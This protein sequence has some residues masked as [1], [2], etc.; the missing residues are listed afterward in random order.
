[1]YRDIKLCNIFTY[2]QYIWDNANIIILR[3]RALT[4]YCTYRKC[5]GYVRMYTKNYHRYSKQLCFR[6][7]LVTR[8][9]KPARPQTTALLR[10]SQ[11]WPART[12]AAVSANRPAPSPSETGSNG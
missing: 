1:M 3:I 10:P 2:I 5:P 8:A 12:R 11:W 4:T 6:P 9:A 7:L